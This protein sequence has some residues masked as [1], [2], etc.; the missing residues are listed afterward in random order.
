[1]I[2]IANWKMYLSFKQEVDLFNK[3]LKEQ[4]T[5]KNLVVCPSFISLKSLNDLKSQT[6][7]DGELHLKI[8]LGAQNCADE[9]FG[10]LTGEVSPKSLREIGAQYCIVGHNE[11]RAYFNENINRINK[12]TNLLIDLQIN[13]IVCIGEPEQMSL[14]K[15]GEVIK[16]QL[17]CLLNLEKVI[18]AYEPVWAIGSDID[19][20]FREIGARINL[21]KS[22]INTK[23]IYGG[24][25][26]SSNIEN[27]KLLPQLDGFLIGRSS[28]DFEELKKIVK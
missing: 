26:K 15:F 28:T 17:E 14:N 10:A 23:V 2:Y 9:N 4:D 22:M 12:K 5:F 16:E 25:I 18:I 24:N 27:L 20:S 3:I 11:R 13:P 6:M 19:I 21:I 7:Q 8:F 1:M